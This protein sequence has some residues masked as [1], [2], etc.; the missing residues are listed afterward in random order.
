MKLKEQLTK[1]IAL[2]ISITG[3]ITF[4]GHDFY[5][6]LGIKQ[7][8][9]PMNILAWVVPISKV[10]FCLL[11]GY[12]VYYVLEQLKKHDNTVLEIIAKFNEQTES[13]QKEIDNYGLLNQIKVDA[14]T[15]YMWHLK[16]A[17]NFIPTSGN[18]N[19]ND[20]WKII[21]NIQK[22]IEEKV[23]I[24]IQS[25]YKLTDI[26]AQAIINSLGKYVTKDRI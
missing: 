5:N 12:F 8:D 23:I 9:F 7:P 25:K 26:E 6:V 22:D 2:F 24:H 21:Y 1:L 15:I 16:N 10:L 11:N 18:E 13:S 19:S 20:F 14:L 4:I 3:F 17:P